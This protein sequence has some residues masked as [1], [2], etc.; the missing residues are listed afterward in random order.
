M[1]NISK[2]LFILY[3]L[4]CSNYITSLLSNKI[5]KFLTDTVFIKHF[6]AFFTIFFFIIYSDQDVTDDK[7]GYTLLYTVILYIWFIFTIKTDYKFFISII[8]IIFIIFILE[9]KY[10]SEKI[11][12]NEKGEK[13]MKLTINILTLIAVI[14]TI[15]G[16]IIYLL[17]KK[18]EFGKDFN[19]IKF[20]FYSNI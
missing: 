7:P 2:S 10:R 11:K 13:K 19:F 3:L 20:M 12:K 14:V 1:F 9:R 15:V 16:Y 4:I 8:F 18:K 5:Q 17:R 6:I